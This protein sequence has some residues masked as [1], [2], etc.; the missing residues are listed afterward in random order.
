MGATNTT[1]TTVVT[2]LTMGPVMEDILKRTT[3]KYKIKAN[4]IAKEVMVIMFGSIIED[5]PVNTAQP[6]DMGMTK[7]NWQLTRGAP[8]T[9]VLKKRQPN[10]DRDSLRPKIPGIRGTFKKTWYFTNN[11]PW[12]RKLEFGGYANPPQFGTY[13][14]QL[15]RFENRTAGGFSLQAP[16]GMFRKNIRRYKTILNSVVA[17]SG[18]LI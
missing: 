5:T 11:V 8:A 1:R 18:N 4:R 7:A 15:G 9:S 3:I 12:I 13:N 17:K 10:R 2:A 14:A 6:N 16:Q